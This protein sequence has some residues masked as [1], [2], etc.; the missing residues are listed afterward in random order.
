[1]PDWVREMLL[2]A[3]Y[4][5]AYAAA[6]RGQKEEIPS[7]LNGMYF[8]SDLSLLN[9]LT[10]KTELLF[11][12]SWVDVEG[13]EHRMNLPLCMPFYS[14]LMEAVLSV[15]TVVDWMGDPRT[16]RGRL[17]RQLASMA[18]TNATAMEAWLKVRYASETE[19]DNRLVGAVADMTRRSPSWY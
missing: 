2:K 3:L 15:D 16:L 11:R 17:C 8:S 12:I 18:R 7:A 6:K 14:N 5:A 10:L 4:E 9:D 1:M 13:V 19:I